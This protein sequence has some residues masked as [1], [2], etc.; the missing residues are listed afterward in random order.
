MIDSIGDQAFYG[1]TNLS[2]CTLSDNITTIGYEAFYGCSNLS[3]NIPNRIS[4]I[5]SFAFRESK[6]LE[7]ILPETLTTM[8]NGVFYDCKSLTTAVIPSTITMIPMNTFNGCNILKGVT[9]NGNITKIGAYAFK[10]SGIYAK[11]ITLN[12]PASIVAENFSIDVDAFFGRYT[13]LTINQKQSL[14]KLTIPDKK[15]GAYSLTINWL[16][17]DGETE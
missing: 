6:I 9:I 13:T 7:A 14:S 4:S 16:P 2:Q 17:E 5:N 8:G 1:C 10:Y 15:W 11:Y 3:V 12:L